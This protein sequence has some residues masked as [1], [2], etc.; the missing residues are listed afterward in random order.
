MG[1]Q[2]MAFRNLQTE[3]TV[4]THFAVSRFFWEFILTTDGSNDFAGTMLSQG[5]IGNDSPIAYASR[6]FNKAERNYS[7]V[8]KELAAIVWGIKHF[9]PIFTVGN[10]K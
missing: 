1:S 2:E 8:E 10:S 9:R 6:S 5:Q 3:I 7:T 4:A